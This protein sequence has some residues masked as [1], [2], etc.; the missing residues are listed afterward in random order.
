MEKWTRSK[1]CWVLL[2]VVFLSFSFFCLFAF[3]LKVVSFSKK[4][5]VVYKP[6]VLEGSVLISQIS[7]ITAAEL[8][9][10]MNS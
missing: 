6:I 7:L 2:F 1:V 9:F 3:S 5:L 4:D 10:H 8:Q